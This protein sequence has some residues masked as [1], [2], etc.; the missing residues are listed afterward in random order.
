MPNI[1]PKTAL[2]SALFSSP[3]PP[4]PASPTKPYVTDPIFISRLPSASSLLSGPALSPP[5]VRFRTLPP[6]GPL[7]LRTRS[8]LAPRPPQ[9]LKRDA[10]HAHSPSLSIPEIRVIVPSSS[11]QDTTDVNRE[12]GPKQLRNSHHRISHVLCARTGWL[13]DLGNSEQSIDLRQAGK[14]DRRRRGITTVEG[15]FTVARKSFAI[16]NS[17]QAKILA[18]R[19]SRTVSGK[20]RA[21]DELES[22]F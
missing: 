18:G 14:R 17:W 4:R 19:G 13:P 15:S 20:L 3:P 1:D 22:W 6:A 2:P 12:D 5:A 16:N 9:S 8:S 11:H 7:H 10:S 21:E